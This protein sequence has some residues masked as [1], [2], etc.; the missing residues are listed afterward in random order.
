MRGGHGEG[1]GLTFPAVRFK[2][3]V[4]QTVKCMVVGGPT[5][6]GKE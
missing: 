6:L 3:Q 5:L 1:K 4:I 2:K